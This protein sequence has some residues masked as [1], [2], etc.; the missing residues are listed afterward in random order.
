MTHLP[1]HKGLLFKK[2]KSPPEGFCL[3]RN[4]VS[5]TFRVDWIIWCRTS[6]IDAALYTRHMRNIPEIG[7]II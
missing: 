6:S 1:A 2:K 4:S 3:P 5:F 7:L